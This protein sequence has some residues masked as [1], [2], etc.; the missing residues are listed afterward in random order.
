MSGLVSLTNP[1]QTPSV[2]VFIPGD[3]TRRNGHSSSSNNANKTSSPSNSRT[4]LGKKTPEKVPTTESLLENPELDPFMLK[5]ARD[6]IAR[7]VM[8]F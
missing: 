7:D 8:R 3:P 2:P 6:A 1:P 4:Q 5:L